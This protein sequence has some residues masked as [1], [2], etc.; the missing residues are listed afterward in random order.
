[1]QSESMSWH[2]MQRRLVQSFGLGR[3]TQTAA[4]LCHALGGKP[5][6]SGCSITSPPAWST[7]CSCT[8][9]WHKLWGSSEAAHKRTSWWAGAHWQK[10]AHHCITSADDTA[11]RALSTE[12]PMGHFLSGSG[13]PPQ[14]TAK[15]QHGHRRMLKLLP[16]S[17]GEVKPF[18]LRLPGREWHHPKFGPQFPELLNAEHLLQCPVHLLLWASSAPQGFSESQEYPV[19]LNTKHPEKSGSW[20][21]LSASRAVVGVPSVCSRMLVCSTNHT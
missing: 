17:M 2:Y 14:Q 19:L 7:A 3:L 13:F 12:G 21:K 9:H 16:D 18:F 15:L 6:T 8:G 20:M 4:F 5:P 11:V 10:G 1:M